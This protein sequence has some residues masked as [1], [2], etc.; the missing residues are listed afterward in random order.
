M[1]LAALFVGVAR[2]NGWRGVQ[3]A[4]QK[5]WRDVRVARQKGWRDARVPEK[6]VWLPEKAE[7]V[8]PEFAQVQKAD[9][10]MMGFL[11][12]ACSPG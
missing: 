10:T 1:G 2:Q 6:V 5:G 11:E 3:V 8:V 12:L 4:R 9:G 7:V